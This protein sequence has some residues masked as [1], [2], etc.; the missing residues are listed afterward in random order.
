MGVNPFLKL[1]NLVE[2]AIVIDITEMDQVTEFSNQ[3]VHRILSSELIM[4]PNEHEMLVDPLDLARLVVVH[5]LDVLQLLKEVVHCLP[6]LL[7]LKFML[8]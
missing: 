1:N 3:F 2:L 5:V 6:N 7:E 4:R 8:I